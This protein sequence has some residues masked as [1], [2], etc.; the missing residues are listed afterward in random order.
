[1]IN[2]LYKSVRVGLKAV[3]DCTVYQEDVPQNFKTP[4][5]MVTIYEQNPSRGINGRL[6][7]EVNMDILY[8]P[9]NKGKDQIQEE[10]WMVGQALTREFTAPGFKLKNRN[11]KIED[12]VL[13]FLFDV[14][15]REVR[16]DSATAMQTMI[17]DT[18]L[19][20]E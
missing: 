19:K 4:S 2:E 15:Y 1:M 18:K 20:E 13:H 11:L 5:F 16:E 10:C 8:F 14:D 6:K 12:D 3:K 7:N 9:E 17:Q